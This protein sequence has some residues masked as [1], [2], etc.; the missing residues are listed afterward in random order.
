[1]KK[2]DTNEL[3]YKTYIDSQISK[4]K[5]KK[6]WFPKWTSWVEKWAV[7]FRLAYGYYC[8]R[9]EQSVGTC[10]IAQGTLPNIL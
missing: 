7:V 9:N 3:I 10:C 2:N 5:N 6:L 1:M 4:N 8:I